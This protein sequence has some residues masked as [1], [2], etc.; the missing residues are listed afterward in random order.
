MRFNPVIPK[1][2]AISVLLVWTGLVIGV[3][4][5]HLVLKHNLLLRFQLMDSVNAIGYALT[6]YAAMHDGQLAAS[7]DQLVADGNLSSIPVNP[8]TEE[9]L[10]LTTDPD[11][12]GMNDVYMLIE[13]SYSGTNG[14]ELI[15]Y[16]KDG[17]VLY[18]YGPF[19]VGPTSS[20]AVSE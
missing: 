6:D 1:R 13:S 18:K 9:Q 17:S 14:L 8:F 7:L 20:K 12:K 19:V 5:D 16:K 2:V 11:H 4:V 3:S 15:V 10:Q